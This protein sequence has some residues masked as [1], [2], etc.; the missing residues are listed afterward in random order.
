MKCKSECERKCTCSCDCIAFTSHPR[1]TPVAGTTGRPTILKEQPDSCSQLTRPHPEQLC[2]SRWSS[3]TVFKSSGA[4]AAGSVTFTRRRPRLSYPPATEQ[5]THVHV[6]VRNACTP[7]PADVPPE[8]MFTA[9]FC[10]Q[11][12]RFRCCSQAVS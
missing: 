5:E 1:S 12:Y 10:T 3:A 2:L 6:H 4:Y 11:V 8:T 9:S 7:A